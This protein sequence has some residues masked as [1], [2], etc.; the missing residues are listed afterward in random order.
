MR[1]RRWPWWSG[2]CAAALLGAGAHAESALPPSLPPECA[3]TLPHPLDRLLQ[4]AA[5]IGRVAESNA[6]L[7]RA[8]RE[9]ARAVDPAAEVVREAERES[10]LLKRRGHEWGLGIRT[11]VS[12]GQHVV[13]AVVPGGP[14]DGRLR[15]GDVLDRVAGRFVTGV[16]AAEWA[17]WIARATGGIEVVVMRPPQREPMTFAVKP[18]WVAPEAVRVELLPRGVGLVQVGE[19]REGV[20][21][22]VLGA[23]NLASTAGAPGVVLDLRRAGGFD[24]SEA[25]RIA[26]AARPGRPQLFRLE[27]QWPTGA[28]TVVGSAES[29]VSHPVP[30][31]LLV[32]PD[33]RDA[34]EALAAALA[35]GG[36]PVIRIGAPTA[37]SLCRYDLV[38]LAR[39][40]FVWLPVRRLRLDG[41][42]VDAPLKPDIEVGAAVRAGATPVLPSANLNPR[43]RSSSEEEEDI[44]LRRRVAGDRQLEYAVDLLLTLRALGVRHDLRR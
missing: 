7:E 24:L 8:L 42:E 1:R 6:V 9:A 10:F 43:R 21:A 22:R 3:E 17:G 4:V 11:E 13:V 36:A 32:G 38:P 2:V 15:P 29:P 26:A 41:V 25:A 23:W 30:L 27:A 40:F 19:L 34:A 39:D 20:A 31:A 16:A 28:C 44:K 35:D 37:G 12:N 18:G 5:A 14:A 33:T